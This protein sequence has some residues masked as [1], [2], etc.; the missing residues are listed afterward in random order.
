MAEAQQKSC[1]F[2]PIPN[3]HETS[4]ASLSN[5]CLPFG[6]FIRVVLIKTKCKVP[7]S[8]HSCELT[9]CSRLCRDA[10]KHLR[11]DIKTSETNYFSLLAI[12]FSES[13]SI[14]IVMVLS[15][16]H[17]HTHSLTQFGFL[18]SFNFMTNCHSLK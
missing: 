10:H 14:H 13:D 16:L 3:G 12:Q 18:K 5:R 9:S 8:L 7:H 4:A 6:S 2:F 1:D 17:T 11:Y 15:V